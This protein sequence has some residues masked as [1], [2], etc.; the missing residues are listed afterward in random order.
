MIKIHVVRARTTV[1][2][3]ARRAL[4][5]VRLTVVTTETRCT[6]ARV[7]IHVIVAGRAV[8]T[9]SRVTFVDIC[10]TLV[11]TVAADAC[12]VVAVDFVSTAAAVL[13]RVRRAFVNIC[14]AEGACTTRFTF[15]IVHVFNARLKDLSQQ[16]AP[17]RGFH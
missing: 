16:T 13:T 17:R 8:L 12:A 3:R 14:R 6:R 5:I 4:I 9:R 1:S 15:I 2:T 11:A 7:A 10:L